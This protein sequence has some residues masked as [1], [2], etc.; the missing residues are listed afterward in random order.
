[1][2]SKLNTSLMIRER[3]LEFNRSLLIFIAM[4]D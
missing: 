4:L 2:I 1:V 3:Y